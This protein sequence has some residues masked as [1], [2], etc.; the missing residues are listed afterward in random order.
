MIVAVIQDELY[1]VFYFDSPDELPWAR[2]CDLDEA[3]MERYRKA[4]E[5]LESVS[6]EV[7]AVMR[8]TER[9]P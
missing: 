2:K 1:P 9:V 8:L 4:L 3:L 6:E 7:K 5:G